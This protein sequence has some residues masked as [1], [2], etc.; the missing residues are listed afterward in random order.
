MNYISNWFLQFWINDYDNKTDVLTFTGMSLLILAGSNLARVARS[1]V[2]MVGTTDATRI[3]NFEM[4][5]SLG[6][7]SLSKFFDKVPI[8]R[9]LNRFSKDTQVVDLNLYNQIDK[10]M[11]LMY[12]SFDL[13]LASCSIWR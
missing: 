10:S 7:A 1:I 2:L 11:I 6:H 3:T 5:Y 4:L 8:G 9:V 12:P 13:G